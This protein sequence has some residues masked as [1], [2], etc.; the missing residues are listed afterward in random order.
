MRS[1]ATPPSRALFADLEEY[2]HDHRPHGPLTADA[3][4]PAWNGYL[5]N[6]IPRD[7]FWDRASKHLRRRIWQREGRR[8]DRVNLQEGN[9]GDM[10]VP[11]FTALVQGTTDPAVLADQRITR[12]AL[13]TLERL[14][15]ATRTRGL[16]PM[17][18][19][20]RFS[21]Q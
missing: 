5:L 1:G 9:K 19:R 17:V 8:G 21:E 2:V 4:K 7:A 6:L 20:P 16:T 12:R 15:R 11:E 3:T 13:Q 14:P 18:K 10:T